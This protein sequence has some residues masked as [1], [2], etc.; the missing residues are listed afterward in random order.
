MPQPKPEGQWSCFVLCML[1]PLITSIWEHGSKQMGGTWNLVFYS[2]RKIM[3][4]ESKKHGLFISCVS[5]MSSHQVENRGGSPA[6]RLSAV[7]FL[8]ES[9]LGTLL[10]LR[11]CCFMIMSLTIP[12]HFGFLTGGLWWPYHKR[13]IEINYIKYIV[14]IALRDIDTTT[15]DVMWLY[16]TTFSHQSLVWEWRNPSS[17]VAKRMS[18]DGSVWSSFILSLLPEHSL[19]DWESQA[20][21]SG[22]VYC[23]K[24]WLFSTHLLICNCSKFRIEVHR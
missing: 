8:Q 21:L 20:C 23:F 17:S 7:E 22:N 11:C 15:N 6:C 12:E 10:P 19:F 16:H 24:L 1:T 14:H 3:C 4:P 13:V 9:L 18:L 2:S 5:V